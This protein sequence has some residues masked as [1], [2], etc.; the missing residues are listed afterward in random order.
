MNRA[1]QKKLRRQEILLKALDLF[2]QKGYVGTKTKEIAKALEMSE[3]LLFHY[4]PTKEALYLELVKLGV[5]GVQVFGK[6]IEDP[7]KVFY[8]IIEHFFQKAKES[9][10]V[11]KMFILIDRAQNKERTPEEVYKV[12]TTVD[13]IRDS[14]P[15]IETGQKKGVFRSGDPL[16]LSFTLWNAVQGNMEALARNPEMDVPDAA[17]IMSILAK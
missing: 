13:T 2:V 10:S 3:G 16:S 17:W 14:V 15:I 4:F 8:D 6:Q 5:E 11:A 9:R 12:A 1:E 7:Y